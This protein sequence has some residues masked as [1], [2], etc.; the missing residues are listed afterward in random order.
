MLSGLDEIKWRDLSHAYGDAGNVPQMIRNLMSSDED[1][2]EQQGKW[3]LLSTIYHQGNVYQATGYAIPFL[4]ELLNSD[5]PSDKS[6]VASCLACIVSG[7][8]SV[9]G[10]AAS[11]ESD[12]R[13]ELEAAGTTLEQELAS[14]RR[15]LTSFRTESPKAIPTITPFIDDVNPE[16][17]ENVAIALGCFAKWRDSSLS[18][19]RKR[20]VSTDAII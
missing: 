3:E 18:V 17:R 10:F 13:K 8:G 12:C 14:E 6:V 15:S 20:S 2:R 11:D 1:M 19:L 5:H 4:I 16:T 7:V 9:E